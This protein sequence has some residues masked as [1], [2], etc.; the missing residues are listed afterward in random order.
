MKKIIAILWIVAVCMPCILTFSVSS[1]D[2]LTVWNFVGLAY[3]LA[4]YEGLFK[5]LVPDWMVKYL[6]HLVKA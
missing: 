3:S 4:L 1:A 5:V 2:T 6:I